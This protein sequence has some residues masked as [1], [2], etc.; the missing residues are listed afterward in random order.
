[1]NSRFLSHIKDKNLF[2]SSQSLLLSISGGIDSVVLFHLLRANKINFDAAHINHNTRDGDSDRDAQFVQ[3]LCATHQVKLHF[4]SLKHTAVDENFQA[5]ARK[6]RYRFLNALNYDKILTAHHADDN[7]ETVLFHF[8]TGRSCKTIPQNNGKVV[9]P[10]LPFDKAEILEY[11]QSNNIEFV[12]DKT[13]EQNSYDR[14]FLRNIIIPALDGHFTQVKKRILNLANQ[15]NDNEELLDQCA[16]ELLELEKKDDRIYIS[17]S[18][19]GEGKSLLLYHAIKQFGFNINQAEDINN[20]K[21]QIGNQFFSDAYILLIDRTYI[22]IADQS[23]THEI[24]AFEFQGLPYS[25]SYGNYIFN[26]SLPQGQMDIHDKNTIYC[27]YQEIGDRLTI[28]VWQDGDM[29]YP[30]GMGG[31]SQSLKKFFANNKIDRLRKKE[32]PILCNAENEIIWIAGLR[33]DA[34]FHAESTSEGAI[35]ISFAE[36]ED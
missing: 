31:H 33:Q 19:L 17:K 23:E 18:K 35:Q 22:I 13:N 1:V 6:Q 30:L 27:N 26:F 9:R 8:V 14:N 15:I 2:D 16:A 25:V 5:F 4:K 20:T 34:R 7:L 28:R 24:K 10:L 3:D 12:E 21:D 36:I 29:F 11:A 32:I